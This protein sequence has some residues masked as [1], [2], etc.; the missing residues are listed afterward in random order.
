MYQERFKETN[1]E[2]LLKYYEC[3]HSLNMV[4]ERL[5]K[6]D[7]LVAGKQCKC[8]Q[9]S[10]SRYQDELHKAGNDI[11]CLDANLKLINKLSARI[12]GELRH[13]PKM[14]RFLEE[15]RQAEAKLAYFRTHVPECVKT[16]GKIH[17]FVTSIEE[18]V[19]LIESWCAEADC[20]IRAEP[21]H[22]T[23]DQLQQQLDKQRVSKRLIL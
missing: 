3:E 12:G 6:I 8:T 5:S 1:N 11:E 9:S 15:L 18:G 16:L 13:D 19:Q 20:L 21:E 23:L 7:S 2:Q 17:S 14:V 10:V 22:L 4:R